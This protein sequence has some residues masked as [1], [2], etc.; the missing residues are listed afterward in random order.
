VPS[1]SSTTLPPSYKEATSSGTK[2]GKPDD[3][4]SGKTTSH[5]RVLEK[6]TKFGQSIQRL[7]PGSGDKGD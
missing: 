4:M 2:A 3:T 7:L 5:Q 1:A 6:A